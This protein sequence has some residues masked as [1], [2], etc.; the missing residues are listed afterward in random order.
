M[1]N[2]WVWGFGASYIRDSTVNQIGDIL[3]ITFHDDAIKKNILCIAGQLVASGFLSQRA[4]NAELYVSITVSL[5][6]LFNK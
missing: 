5:E 4:R 3:E 6:K 1:R 2:I